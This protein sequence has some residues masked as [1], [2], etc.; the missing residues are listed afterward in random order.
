MN[1]VHSDSC[2]KN[3]AV[4]ESLVEEYR[5]RWPH[6][7]RFCGGLGGFGYSF[8]PSPAGVSLSP[9]CYWDFEPC[10]ECMGR[11]PRCYRE[12]SDDGYGQTHTMFTVKNSRGEMVRPTCG[13]CGF[14]LEDTRGLPQKPECF[15]YDE[16]EVSSE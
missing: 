5:K 4:Y 14:V 7:C 1:R 10:E 15:C 8:D 2:A 16:K 11:C 12:N 6:Y 3:I 9:G 13:Y